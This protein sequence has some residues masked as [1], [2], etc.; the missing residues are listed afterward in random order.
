MNWSAMSS[1]AV[2]LGTY[3][4]EEQ[5]QGALRA[6]RSRAVTPCFALIGEPTD[7]HLV[8]S[9]KGITHLEIVIP[10]QSEMSDEWTDEGSIGT[11]QNKVFHG[12]AAH[13]STPR[14]GKTLWKRCLSF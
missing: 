9:G 7:L 1:S 13:S 8:Y 3:G 5:M 6:I 2:L 10:H 4:E 11:T 12:K 14:W